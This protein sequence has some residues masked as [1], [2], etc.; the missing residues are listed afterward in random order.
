M[1]VLVLMLV[2]H[3]RILNEYPIFESYEILELTFKPNT[4]ILLIGPFSLPPIQPF[5]PFVHTPKHELRPKQRLRRALQ[6]RPRQLQVRCRRVKS[7]F[8]HV[9]SVLGVQCLVSN[10]EYEDSRKLMVK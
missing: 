3:V 6:H 5:S 10:Y 1:L 7:L 9:F 8:R 2:L 4:I